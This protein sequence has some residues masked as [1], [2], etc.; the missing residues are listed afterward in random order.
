MLEHTAATLGVIVDGIDHGVFP[1][2]PAAIASTANVFRIDCDV[3]DPDGLGT[4]ELR[5]QWSRKRS[6]PAMA[7]YAELAEPLDDA[8]EAVP[9]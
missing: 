4:V 7:A 5:G 6:D 2:H 8:P 1:A 9:A 3:C